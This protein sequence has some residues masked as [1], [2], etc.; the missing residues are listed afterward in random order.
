M[1]E[2]AEQIRLEEL[3]AG[4]VTGL[5]PEDSA[6]FTKLGGIVGEQF[7]R[8]IRWNGPF[9]EDLEE[10]IREELGLDEAGWEQYWV[11]LKEEQDQDG[12]GSKQAEGM[13]VGN[14]KIEITI[15]TIRQKSFHSHFPRNVFG[16]KR[17]DAVSLPV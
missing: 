5:D 11:D 7:A 14:L 2:V 17:P 3:R 4:Y 1:K 15:L 10:G 6:Y 12:D 13:Q 9:K 8:G 16:R